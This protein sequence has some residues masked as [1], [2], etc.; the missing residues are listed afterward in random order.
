MDPSL[1]LQG[2]FNSGL[3]RM[4]K[5]VFCPPEEEEGGI[6]DTEHY[7]VVDPDSG[8]REG[9]GGGGALKAGA[10]LR[11]AQDIL[12]A[13]RVALLRNN[14]LVDVKLDAVS[15]VIPNKR[16]YEVIYNRL[17]ND[18]LLWM[19]TYMTVKEWLAPKKSIFLL[20]LYSKSSN[21]TLI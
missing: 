10:F 13:L 1:K 17:G 2:R 18:L 20:I 6:Q 14:L 16:L 8:P 7:F 19:P 12:A 9:G 15:V 11:Q 3:H 4:Q 21:D 5:S